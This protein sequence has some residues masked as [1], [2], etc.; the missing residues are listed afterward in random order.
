VEA[1]GSDELWVVEDLG[2]GQV[3][4]AAVLEAVF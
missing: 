3:K 1:A 4:H 2:R